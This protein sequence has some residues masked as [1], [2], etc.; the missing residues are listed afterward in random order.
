MA[1]KARSKGKPKRAVVVA[2]SAA[3]AIIARLATQIVGMLKKCAGL[4]GAR[5]IEVLFIGLAAKQPTQTIGQRTR[6]QA[7]RL[8]K[9]LVSSP[10][11]P[12]R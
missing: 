8:G 3:P 9:R 7:R 5:K 12:T 4:L 6:K 10:G 2:A 1:P 11:T